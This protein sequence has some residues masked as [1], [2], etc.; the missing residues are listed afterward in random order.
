[1]QE[2]SSPN[3]SACVGESEPLGASAQKHGTA[4]F[5]ERYKS[6]Q[7]ITNHR[8]TSKGEAVSKQAQANA[9]RNV[10]SCKQRHKRGG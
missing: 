5:A 4:L 2:L 9:G 6:L 8:K 1:M 10:E 3:E 7:I